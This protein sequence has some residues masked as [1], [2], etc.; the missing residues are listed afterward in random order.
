MWL[1]RKKVDVLQSSVDDLEQY[2]WINNLIVSGVPDSAS[3][4]GLEE[5]VTAILSGID[6]QVTA[7]NV[8][9]CHRI[10]QSDEK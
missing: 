3:D 6:V 2:D 5:T 7:N 4:D 8:E 9:D 10:G 1:F